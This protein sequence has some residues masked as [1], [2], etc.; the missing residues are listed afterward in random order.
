M[1]ISRMSDGVKKNLQFFIRLCEC[2]R[3]RGHLGAAYLENYKF[4]E[5]S[6]ARCVTRRTL[7]NSHLPC[8]L[9]IFL[10]AKYLSTRGLT[11]PLINRSRIGR[12]RQ[13]RGGTLARK[14][15]PGILQLSADEQKI[16]RCAHC[17]LSSREDGCAAAAAG[18]AN[19]AS[20][21]GDF[22]RRIWRGG[23]EGG[24]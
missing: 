8:A 16:L 12:A 15:A 20:P 3:E 10:S 14:H 7:P 9:I 21:F 22:S 18:G 23:E 19:F 4:H 5:A 11:Y 6:R 2:A 17:Y 24:G 1:L 13:H